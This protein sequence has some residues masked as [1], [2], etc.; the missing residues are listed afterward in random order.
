[1]VAFGL[2]KLQRPGE[3]L[4][5]GVG[6]AGEVA[7]FHPDVVVDADPGEQRDLLPAQACHPAVAAIGGQAGLPGGDPRPPGGEELADLRSVV[8]DF[9]VGAPGAPREALPLPGTTV[10]ARARRERVTWSAGGA[11][12]KVLVTP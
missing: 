7:A 4:E 11:S 1:M 5:D 3:A 9:T 6:G 10:T 12:I 2:I 8:H